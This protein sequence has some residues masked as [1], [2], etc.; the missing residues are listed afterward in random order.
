MGGIGSGTGIRPNRKRN[1]QFVED[2]PCIDA[3]IFPFSA[4]SILPSRACQLFTQ[5]V[6]F[7]IYSEKLLIGQENSSD[8]FL[9]EIFFSLTPA[10]YG[11]YRYWFKCPKCN[12]RRRNLSLVRVDGFPLFLCRC[13][14]KL[15][16]QSQNRTLSDQIIHKKWH[17]I[18][19][20]GGTSE[21]ISD[22]AKPKGMHWKTFCILREQITWLHEKALLF[23]PQV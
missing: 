19:K 22:S 7:R 17:L 3:S 2:F 12:R 1:K 4:M 21:Y 5:G 23:A 20:L 16:Y 14:L 11:N 13:C 10:H 9:Y 18:R 6:T 8:A 15:V